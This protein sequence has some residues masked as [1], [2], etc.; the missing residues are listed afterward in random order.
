MPA[1]VSPVF[2]NGA[3]TGAMQFLYNAASQE[4]WKFDKLSK[5]YQNKTDTL[6]GK[7]FHPTALQDIEEGGSCATRLSN[8][9]NRAGYDTL[10]DAF[11][12]TPIT[13]VGDG[14]GGRYIMGA[15]S[16]ADH[17]GVDGASYIVNDMSS[18][19]GKRGIIYFENYHIDLYDGTNMVGNGGVTLGYTDNKIYFMELK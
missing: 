3:S 11:K 8:A 13:T 15:A 14:L 19:Q 12:N 18:I 4:K 9:F 5:S 1:S 17:L 6:T 7:K 10:G 2:A 16:L